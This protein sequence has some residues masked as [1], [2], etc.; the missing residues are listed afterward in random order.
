M[1][2]QQK[3]KSKYVLL[4]LFIIF[5]QLLILIK[6]LNPIPIEI[7]IMIIL[8]IIIIAI[9]INIYIQLFAKKEIPKKLMDECCVCY[10]LTYN[11]TSCCKHNVCINCNKHL[12]QVAQHHKMC[13]C[14]R[15]P[16]FLTKID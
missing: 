3:R 14:C 10:N 4:S 6:D 2:P 12:I 1:N 8:E 15:Q 7:I 9:Q 13:P 16:F 11:I 5:L